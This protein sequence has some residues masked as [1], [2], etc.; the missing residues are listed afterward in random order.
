MK[1]WFE[2]LGV[3]ELAPWPLI[4]HAY[5]DKW[6]VLKAK[7]FPTEEEKRQLE[8][9]E[10]AF[11]QAKHQRRQLLDT[12]VEASAPADKKP[13][14]ETRMTEPVWQEIPA[15]EKET[16]QHEEEI[17]WAE[18][19]PEPRKEEESV[20]C[21]MGYGLAALFILGVAALLILLLNL[22]VETGVAGLIIVFVLP[23]V[24]YAIDRLFRKKKPNR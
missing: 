9:L 2:V 21:F 15:P 18:I 14:T 13:P 19:I 17:P 1:P 22:G 7:A 8:A 10:T 6:A 3:S 4:E 20:G 12:L 16:T 5:L 11:R 23:V 24:L